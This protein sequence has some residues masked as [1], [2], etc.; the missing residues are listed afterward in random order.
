MAKR[1]AVALI[2]VDKK[3]GDVHTTMTTQQQRQQ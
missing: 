3:R 1:E 2:S